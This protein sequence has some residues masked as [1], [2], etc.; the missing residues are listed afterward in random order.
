MC[1]GP[2]TAPTAMNRDQFL[3][4]MRNEDAYQAGKRAHCAA[5]GITI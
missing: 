3:T 5:V 1:G 2:L 4:L